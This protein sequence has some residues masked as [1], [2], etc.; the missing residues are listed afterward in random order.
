MKTSHGRNTIGDEKGMVLITALL[1]ITVLLLLGS[2]GIMTTT[3]DMKIST[4]YKGSVMSLYDA[5]AGVHYT[6]GGIRNSVI[7]LPTSGTSTPTLTA[8]TGFS[9]SGIT[10]TNLGSNQYRLYST[11]N[12][13]NGAQK[14]LEVVFKRQSLIPLGADG[15]LC[16]YGNLPTVD[17]KP[18]NNPETNVNGN[19]YAI[20]GSFNCSGAGCSGSLI[21]GAPAAPG[22]F[23][24]VSPTITGNL[25]HA[26]GDPPTQTGSGSHTEQEW[27]DFA[28]YIV[29]NNLYVEGSM[30]TRAAPAVTV[31]PSGST[32]AG[33]GDGAGILIIADGGEVHFTG[34]F[35]Y[36]GLVILL[37]TGRMF[38]SGSARL[39]GS[40]VT[41]NHAS[42]TVDLTGSVD[43]LYS[44]QALANLANIGSLQTI[45]LT[46]WKDTAIN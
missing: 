2:T 29:D 7:S 13:A 18:G 36:E 34:N 3:T 26:D 40:T 45:H 28:N 6:I 25:D 1:L 21:S 11:G 44:S 16:M 4:N 10:L 17:L 43:I 27:I 24:T 20:P 22:I 15:A 39:F 19:D 12:A 37:G 38:G 33:N 32:L 8:P 31:V 30:G 42:K 14:A 5:E 35:H 46:S 41:A 9:F 23:T